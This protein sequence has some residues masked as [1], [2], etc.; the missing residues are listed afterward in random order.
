MQQQNNT[1]RELARYILQTGATVRAAAAYS[2]IPKSTVHTLVTK[3][4]RRFDSALAAEVDA[5][6]QKN[7]AER[8]IRGGLATREKYKQAAANVVQ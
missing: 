5:V 8:H 4:L 6:L 2:G 3:T 1:A 7:K